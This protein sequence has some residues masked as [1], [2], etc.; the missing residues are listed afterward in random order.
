V[1]ARRRRQPRAGV[2]RQAVLWPAL[3]GARERLLSSFLGKVEVAEEA[4]QRRKD[5]APLLAEDLLD[6]QGST[7]NR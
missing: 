7:G 3:R 6:G 5:T 1:V 2:A 4:D